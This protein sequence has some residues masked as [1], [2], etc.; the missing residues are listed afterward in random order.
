MPSVIQTSP[1][2]A[3][4]IDTRALMQIRSLELRARIV[5]QGFWSGI[6]RSPYHGFSAEFTEY[7]Q[8]VPGDDTRYLDWRLYARSDRY[9]VKKF[10]DETNLRC[11]LL[12]D[13][14]RSMGFGS[15]DW[16]KADYAHTLAATLAYFLFQQ[17]DA[18]GLLSFEENIRDY[19]PAR[20][21]PGHLR[22]IM[23]SLEKE[24]AGNSTDLT[25]PLKRIVELVNKRGLMVLISDL[26]APVDE[27]ENQLGQLTA[28]GHEVI[29][30]RV[31]D[32]REVDFDFEEAL[33]FHDA[34]TEKDFFI[35]PRAAQKRY[36]TQFGEHDKVIR[37]LCNKLGAEYI[38][39]TSDQPLEQV[40]SDFLRQRRNRGKVIRRREN[41]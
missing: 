27:L 16:S 15:L 7:R 23:L 26:L 5:A 37:T 34:E 24:A 35:D 30:F 1:R 11:H 12:L 4:L 39:V 18:V 38:P 20:N 13:Q 17:G 19:L 41:R 3:Q 10:E 33:L 32:P 21:R 8:Y 28:S 9:Y 29:V 14:S 31:L 36:L 2:R 40:L 22:Q 25:K 6:H